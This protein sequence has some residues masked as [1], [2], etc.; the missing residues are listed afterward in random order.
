MCAYEKC[1]GRP[2][3]P[4]HAYIIVENHS[5]HTQNKDFCS[6]E[7]AAGYVRSLPGD[8]IITQEYFSVPD[9]RDE[10]L[11]VHGLKISL[12]KNETSKEISEMKAPN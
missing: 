9:V 6:L 11:V 7:C 5:P 3:L 10:K 8:W 2:P 4:R 1:S 12:S